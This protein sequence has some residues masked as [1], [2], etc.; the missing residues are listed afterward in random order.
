MRHASTHAC[1]QTRAV[2]LRHV[3]HTGVYVTLHDHVVIVDQ[4]VLRH[5]TLPKA[6]GWK[7]DG[8]PVPRDR[9]HA[10]QLVIEAGVPLLVEV[11]HC[12]QIT[13]PGVWITPNGERL[14]LYNDSF[15]TDGTPAVRVDPS[16]GRTFVFIDTDPDLSPARVRSRAR[17]LDRVIHL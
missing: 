4:A 2:N 11:R 5:G 7:M 14:R 3:T 9:R 16:H 12:E 15:R 17:D 10:C 8:L 13:I 6:F 1:M